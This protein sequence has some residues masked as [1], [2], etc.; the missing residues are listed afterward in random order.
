MPSPT[1]RTQAVVRDLDRRLRQW[2]H[3]T[4]DPLTLPALT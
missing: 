3:E 1:P 2:Q 4:A